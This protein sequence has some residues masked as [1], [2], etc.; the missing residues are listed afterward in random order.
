MSQPLARIIQHK[1]VGKLLDNVQKVCGRNW[2]WT[3][4][5]YLSGSTEQNMISLS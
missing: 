1:I 2:S 4:L 5:R 3:N